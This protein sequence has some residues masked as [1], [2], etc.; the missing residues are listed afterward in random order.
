MLIIS[1]IL[2]IADAPRRVPPGAPPRYEPGTWDLYLTAGALTSELLNTHQIVSL[3][4]WAELVV[5]IIEKERKLCLCYM[6]SIV[7]IGALIK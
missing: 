3:I 2:L 5:Y 6:F 1:P 7:T 4:H